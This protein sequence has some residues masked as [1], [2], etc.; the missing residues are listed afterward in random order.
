MAEP[1]VVGAP[2]GDMQ[3]LLG[4]DFRQICSHKSELLPVLAAGSFELPSTIITEVKAKRVVVVT[5]LMAAKVGAAQ[6]R[7]AAS[8]LIVH[9]RQAGCGC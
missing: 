6:G 7:T 4:V 2:S 5:C 8:R 9:A 1:C 3:W